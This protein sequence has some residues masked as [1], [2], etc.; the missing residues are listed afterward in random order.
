M[1][2]PATPEPNNQEPRVSEKMWAVVVR[3]EF[4]GAEWFVIPSALARTRRDSIAKFD[5][6]ERL[7]KWRYRNMRRRGVARAVRVTVTM[8]PGQLEKE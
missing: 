6:S 8:D 4:L 1:T 7:P 5:Q 3:G 2:H